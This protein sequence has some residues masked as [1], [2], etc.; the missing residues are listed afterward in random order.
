MLYI[1]H[2]LIQERQI[3]FGMDDESNDKTFFREEVLY[4]CF[5][6][7]PAHLVAMMSLKTKLTRLQEVTVS[8]T[9]G[10]NGLGPPD[11]HRTPC[12]VRQGPE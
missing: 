8:T 5:D 11:A 6:Y 2:T 10:Q 9:S 12:N 7:F 1:L 4:V 3:L